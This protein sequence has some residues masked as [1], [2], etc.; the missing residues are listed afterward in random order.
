MHT[1]NQNPML[2]ILPIITFLAAV[3]Q[4]LT[5]VIF[6]F[7]G[8]N[9]VN[10]LIIPANYAF[11]IWGAI[12]FGC[13]LFAGYQL[14]YSKLCGDKF[15]NIN[16]PSIALFVCFSIWLWLASFNQ[17][18]GTLIVFLVMF[19]LLLLIHS[20]LKNKQF[21]SLE[22]VIVHAPFLLY[23][24]WTTIAIFANFTSVIAEQG[25]I[26]SGEKSLVSY[27]LIL[28]AALG[29]AVWVGTR[30]NFNWYYVG[31][32]IWAF[33]AITIASYLKSSIIIPIVCI[34]AIIIIIISK[35][36]Y[37]NNKRELTIKS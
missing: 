35:F 4:L 15:Y 21:S 36:I 31:T 30:V 25:I 2:K 8:F 6:R 17:Q 1:P 23:L 16:L 33:V 9:T 24:G 18:L 12:T 29:N 10:P 27:I 7:D 19:G 14:F 13:A 26:D 3:S 11:S 32:I 5:P 22:K 28:L 37:K 34:I 20:K